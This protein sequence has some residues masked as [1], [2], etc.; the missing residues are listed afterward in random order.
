MFIHDLQQSD[1]PVTVYT[2]FFSMTIIVPCRMKIEGVQDDLAQDETKLLKVSTLQYFNHRFKKFDQFE[3]PYLGAVPISSF[4]NPYLF[5]DKFILSRAL[6]YFFELYDRY[7]CYSGS[8]DKSQIQEDFDDIFHLAFLHIKNRSEKIAQYK[9]D[10]R[11]KKP[12][13]LPEKFKCY[14]IGAKQ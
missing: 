9:R 8:K 10:L 11:N 12:V 7:N 1:C 2:L 5:R 3:S 13:K 14:S 4:R 6:N